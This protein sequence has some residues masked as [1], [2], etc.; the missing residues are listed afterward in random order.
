MPSVLAWM[1][2]I[3]IVSVAGAGLI[4]SL[5]HAPT[6][7]GRPEL[8]ARGHALVLPRLAAMDG[9]V[10]Q[11]AAAGDAIAGAGRDTLTR[12][13]ALDVTGTDAAMARGDAASAD[14]TAIR[15]RLATARATLLDGTSMTGL[16]DSDRV[17]IG[18][19]DAAM[20]AAGELPGYWS[21]VALVAS[22][23]LD[24]LRA[25][26]AHD[27]TVETA[28]RSGVAGHWADALASLGDAQRLLLPARAVRDVS[29]TAG[30]DVSTLDDLLDRVD[31]Y[32]A[33]LIDLYTSLQGSG[34]TETAGSRAALER[35]N[36]AQESLPTDQTAMVV[37]MS[38]LAGPTITPVLLSVESA[39]GVLETALET[40]LDSQP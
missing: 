12:L 29:H 18:T 25:M 16:R 37:V 28:T 33:A 27:T 13:R 14:V 35:V 9:Q 5:D 7:V 30:L 34:G 40:A 32:D 23:P 17:R 22:G 31:A 4:L 38:D 15:D 8:T 24:L 21:Q 10:Q 39:R 11:L 6:E 36:A 1:G 2:M 19:I 3:L 20:A 26:A